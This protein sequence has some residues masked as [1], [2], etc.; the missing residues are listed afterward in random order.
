M[1]SSDLKPDAFFTTNGKDLWFLGTF[2]MQPTCELTNV[3]TGAV[4]SF[5]MGGLT[6]D[7]FRKITPPDI[8]KGTVE[9]LARDIISLRRQIKPFIK[10]TPNDH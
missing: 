1:N 3:A 6:A 8:A 2:C 7:R 4:E 5:G 10:D 9:D